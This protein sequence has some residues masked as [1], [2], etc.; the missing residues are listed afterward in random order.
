MPFGGFTP[1]MIHV[2]PQILRLAWPLGYRAAQGPDR[3]PSFKAAHWW[4]C[5]L[6]ILSHPARNRAIMAWR[7][8][9]C[10][11]VPRSEHDGKGLPDCRFSALPA[12]RSLSAD[13]WRLRRLVPLSLIMS[14]YR[15]RCMGLPYFLGRHARRRVQDVQNPQ[16]D[17]ALAGKRRP[18]PQGSRPLG[19]RL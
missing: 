17:R 4:P 15:N 3:A 10:A 6:D 12:V 11:P 13:H 16:G 1:E 9:S 18:G 8:V 5:R 2:E 19:R 14:T 7:T